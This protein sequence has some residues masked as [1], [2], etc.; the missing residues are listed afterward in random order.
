V[1]MA[2]VYQSPRPRWTGYTPPPAGGAHGVRVRLDDVALG[3]H[4]PL[5]VPL[6]AG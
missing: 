5:V 3:V 6:T 4:D 1:R 2:E